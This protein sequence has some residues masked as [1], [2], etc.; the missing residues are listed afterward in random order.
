MIV[1]L[2]CKKNIENYI[3]ELK[4]SKTFFHTKFKNRGLIVALYQL[5][6]YR[7]IAE[8]QNPLNKYI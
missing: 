8:L 1:L 6:Y 2:N 5:D 4:T 7:I 3:K